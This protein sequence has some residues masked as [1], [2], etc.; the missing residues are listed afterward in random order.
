M[1]ELRSHSGGEGAPRTNQKYRCPL[2]KV[3]AIQRIPGI[4]IIMN[5]NEMKQD[6]LMLEPTVY[7]L[8]GYPFLLQFIREI[9]GSNRVKFRGIRLEY[10]DRAPSAIASGIRLAEEIKTSLASAEEGSFDEEMKSLRA[11]SWLS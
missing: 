8:E 9:R 3:R 7:G 11:R 5:V 1:W 10:P 6:V 2:P 4:K